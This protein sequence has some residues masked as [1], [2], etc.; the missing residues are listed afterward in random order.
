VNY[1]VEKNAVDLS[2]EPWVQLEDSQVLDQ[3]T[4]NGKVYG[5]TVWNTL[6]TTWVVNYNKEIFD[7]LNLSVPTT[8]A[9]FKSVCETIKKPGSPPFTSQWLMDGTRYYGSRNWVSKSRIPHPGLQKC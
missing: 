6:G 4:V 2:D 9:E 3:S 7:N 5:Q 8:F 1:D